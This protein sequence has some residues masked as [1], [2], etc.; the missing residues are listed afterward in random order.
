MNDYR[1]RFGF[2]TIPF[3]R[4]ISTQQ[5][6]ALDIFDQTLTALHRAVE[7]RTSAALIAPAGTGKTALLRALIAKLPDVRYRVH[8][9]KVTCLSKRDMCR[10]IAAACGAQPAGTYPMLVR[11][12]QERFVSVAST[13]A[14]RPVLIL[15]EAHDLRPDVL[16]ML[17]ILTNFEMDSVLMLS[18]LLVGQPMLHTMLKYSAH[19]AISGRL[20]HIATLRLL[21]R[22]ESSRYIA[23]R[24]NIAGA[25]VVPFDAAA[26]GAIHELGRG[27]LRAIDHLAHKSLE[28][29]HDA[30]AAVVDTNHVVAARSVLLP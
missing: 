24:C 3:T 15:D 18:V 12:L 17:R 11:R 13:D 16:D 19:V 10:E 14:V 20:S 1:S 27:N 6:F 8:Y 23:H 22:E 4:E 28:I 26:M 2:H 30:G 7:A 9:V 21:T 5:R 29:A 25:T